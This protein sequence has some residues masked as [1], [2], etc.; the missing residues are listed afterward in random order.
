MEN[1][2]QACLRIFP[3]FC[4]KRQGGLWG[5][6]SSVFPAQ[7][8]GHSTLEETLEAEVIDYLLPPVGTDPYELWRYKL[9]AVIEI[10]IPQTHHYCMH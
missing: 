6:G 8:K 3:T 4:I 9:S 5:N 1:P 10:L 2:F 7:L